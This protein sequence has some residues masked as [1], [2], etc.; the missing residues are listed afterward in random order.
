MEFADVLAGF[1]PEGRPFPT[2]DGRSNTNGEMN[3]SEKSSLL[4]SSPQGAVRDPGHCERR[5]SPGRPGW[6]WLFAQSLGQGWHLMHLYPMM[7]TG[8]CP[9]RALQAGCA[10]HSANPQRNCLTQA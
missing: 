6:T 2:G 7:W 10:P 8:F 5:S 9:T 4:A 3:G 1:R